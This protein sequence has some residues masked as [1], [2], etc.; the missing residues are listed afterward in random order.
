MILT[1]F[2]FYCHSKR[3]TC[4][5]GGNLRRNLSK[6]KFLKCLI[7]PNAVNFFFNIVMH[8]ALVMH[9][10]KLSKAIEWVLNLLVRLFFISDNSKWMNHFFKIFLL[11]PHNK[12]EQGWNQGGKQFGYEF[13]ADR[14]LN[15]TMQFWNKR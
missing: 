14:E 15:V 6:Q 7:Y 3:K 1:F 11:N 9:S 13:V 5:Y 4:F 2:C 12:C 10:I 8:F